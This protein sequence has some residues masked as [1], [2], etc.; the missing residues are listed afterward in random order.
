[1]KPAP[2][3][4]TGKKKAVL[5]LSGPHSS[6]QRSQRAAV[7]CGCLPA[8]G[9]STSNQ[10]L[11]SNSSFQDPLVPDVTVTVLWPGVSETLALEA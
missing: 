11:P 9:I 2:S 3:S 8:H 10:L 6:L 1:M 4:A 7:T 5:L